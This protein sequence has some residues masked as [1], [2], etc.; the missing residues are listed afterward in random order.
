MRGP[1]RRRGRPGRRVR[2]GRAWPGA[3]GL[4]VAA[5]ERAAGL[6]HLQADTRARR[7]A[8]PRRHGHRGVEHAAAAP[9]GQLG[10]GPVVVRQHRALERPDRGTAVTV[11]A[12]ELARLA[13]APGGSRLAGLQADQVVVH[14][15]VPLARQRRDRSAAGLGPGQVD[16]VG[17]RD[18]RAA[19]AQL[20]RRGV[21][22]CDVD[23]AALVG[24]VQPPGIAKRLDDVAHR[25]VVDVVDQDADHD[26][27]LSSWYQGIP[28][29][30]GLIT[31]AQPSELHVMVILDEEGIDPARVAGVLVC[32]G[33][34]MPSIVFAHGLWADGSCFSKLIPAHLQ[35]G[36]RVASGR[37]TPW[38]SLEGDVDVV[39]RTLARVSGP[40]IL[41]GHSW[42]GVVI[43]AAGT[44]RSRRRARL[45]SPR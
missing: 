42:G 13:R 16:P 9:G 40:V 19:V 32:V 3:A 27:A 15:V 29:P 45:T 25:R 12:D 30:S 20:P 14:D 10:V 17:P 39:H 37:A 28:T 36:H 38:S 7:V 21:G 24:L 41:V 8:Q 33:R 4:G 18:P 22:Q 23:L 34:R 31:R 11:G 1:A 44:R 6:G 35:E 26:R 5:G 2:R 43:T